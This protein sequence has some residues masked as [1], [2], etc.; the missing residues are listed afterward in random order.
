VDAAAIDRLSHRSLPRKAPSIL[1][2][3]HYIFST[4][5]SQHKDPAVVCYLPATFSAGNGRLRALATRP[6]TLC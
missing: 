3:A 1:L 5:T 4:T 2:W 6:L